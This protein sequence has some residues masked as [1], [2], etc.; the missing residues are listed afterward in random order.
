[1]EIQWF[2]IKGNNQTKPCIR[3]LSRRNS[4][5]WQCR[6]LLLQCYLSELNPAILA[7]CRQFSSPPPPV[8]IA[9]IFIRRSSKLGVNIENWMSTTRKTPAS[10]GTTSTSAIKTRFLLFIIIIFFCKVNTFE[11]W[12]LGVFRKRIEL[13]KDKANWFLSFYF[14]FFLIVLQG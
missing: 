10:S 8:N 12:S 3:Q 2:S 14:L 1:M 7:W 5:T 9:G 11:F 6:E 13:F 4:G